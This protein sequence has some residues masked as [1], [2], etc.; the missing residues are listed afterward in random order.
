M[1]TNE[2]RVVVTG[3]GAITPIGLSAPEYWRNLQAGVSGAGPITQFDVSNYPVKIACSVKDFDPTQYMDR[4]DVRRS[5]RFAHFAVAAAGQ[6]LADAEF[7]ITEANADMVGVVFNT[8]GGGLVDI[9][10]EVI[11]MDR[12]GMARVSA[13]FVPMMVPNMAILPGVAAVRGQ[14]APDHLVSRLREQRLRV[15]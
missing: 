6:A 14:G 10:D 2:R 1:D 3:L 11:T 9:A 7:T 12:R 4:R 13:F 15:Y 5:S 8:G